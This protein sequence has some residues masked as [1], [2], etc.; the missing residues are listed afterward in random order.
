MKN[1]IKTLLFI[2]FGMGLAILVTEI[3]ARSIFPDFA[4]GSVYLDK[5]Y[6][7][8]LNSEV[9]FDSNN[10]NFSKKF[11][12]TLSPHSERTEIT[13][14]FTYTMNTNSLGF[15]SKEIQGKQ[16]DEYR[17]MLIGDSMLWGVG[18]EES[19][20][21]SSIIEE[22]GKSL[23]SKNKELSVYNYSVSG[24]N[25]VQ[26]LSVAGA[27]LDLLQPDHIIL[28]FFIA[29]DI[30]PNAIAYI[31]SEGN[32]STSAEMELKIKQELKSKLEKISHSIILRIVALDV[33]IPRVRYQIA[34]SDD[35]ISK[36][37]ALL[38]EFNR[39]SESNEVRF[40]VVIFYPR[41]SVQGGMVGRWS[42]SKQAGKMIHEFCQKNSIESLDLL[43]YMNTVEHR[44]SYFF[45]NDGHPNEM[46]NH[47]IAKAIFNDLV[48]PHVTR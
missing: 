20:M 46:G 21:V 38:T 24:Y 23:P 32:Y 31:N 48:K 9:V 25:T 14:D 6:A 4:D 47:V 40:S 42:N 15:R 33:Y 29:N 13:K 34:V 43:K 26:E 39:L 19:N 44:N 2:L 8:V 11:G 45:E 5:A 12:F 16:R 30:I 37:Y 10:D 17:V 28:G 36:S 41:D 18:V 1:T 27:Y 7:R 22:Q 3:I 35:V